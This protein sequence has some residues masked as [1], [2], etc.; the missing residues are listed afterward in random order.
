[1]TCPMAA[2]NSL[3]NASAPSERLSWHHGGDTDLGHEGDHASLDTVIAAH[4]EVLNHNVETVKGRQCAVRPQARYERSLEVLRYC[5]EQDP[6]PS[7]NTGSTA[8]LGETEDQMSRLMDDIL[9]TGCDISTIGEYLQP[10]PQHYPRLVMP[11]R[12]ISPVGRSWPSPRASAMRH[13]PPWP[14]AP[15]KH[16]KHWRMFMI[17]ILILAHH[18]EMWPLEQHRLRQALFTVK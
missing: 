7:T 13:P 15:T 16:G 17:Y 11:R 14:A 5:K 3:P 6:T 8:G 4:P 2:Q 18:Q 12:K 10:S 9:E 1:M